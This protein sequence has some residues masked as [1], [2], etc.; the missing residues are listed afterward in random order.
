L[1]F[2]FLDEREIN[3]PD[4][5]WMDLGCS[6]LEF[7]IALSR[8]AAFKGEGKPKYWFW[9]MLENVDLARFNDKKYR[10]NEEGYSERIDATL[11][12][13]IWRTYA[14]SGMGNI[15]PLREPRENQR[16]VEVAYQLNAYIIEMEELGAKGA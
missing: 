13:I 11:D 15:F 12:H 16:D 3:D 1:R 8:R 7:L 14:P 10:E 9:L 6:M 5:A 2:E 4:P